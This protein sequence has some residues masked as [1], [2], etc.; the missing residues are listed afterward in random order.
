M[1]KL[2][3]HRIFLHLSGIIAPRA[4]DC[5]DFLC[6]FRGRADGGRNALTNDGFVLCCSDLH[7]FCNGFGLL[8]FAFRLI[9][10][11]D[12]RLF[13]CGILHRIP[14]LLQKLCEFLLCLIPRGLQLFKRFQR[15][16]LAAKLRQ[17]FIQLCAD[18][19]RKLGRGLVGGQLPPLADRLD[20]RIVCILSHMVKQLRVEFLCLS[21]KSVCVGSL[22][23]QRV[24]R[25]KNIS[26]QRGKAVQLRRGLLLDGFH[27]LIAF[28]QITINAV[29]QL[30]ALQNTIRFLCR[31]CPGILKIAPA[32][33]HDVLYG[34]KVFLH[35][36]PP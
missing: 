31:G 30:G 18:L 22:W 36:A 14:H 16:V 6:L 13:Q 2:S 3:V 32:G 4:E 34:T 33:I 7:H 20:R 11:V 21:R 27:A 28:A 9:C 15:A 35:F 24:K 23:E 19:C 25:L 17:Q 12:H 29:L 10:R 1:K 26:G 5:L 8:R